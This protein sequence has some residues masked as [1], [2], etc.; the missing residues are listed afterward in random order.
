MIFECPL[1]RDL[2]LGREPIQRFR[3]FEADIEELSF[4]GAIED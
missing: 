3:A 2:P 1:A 4:G